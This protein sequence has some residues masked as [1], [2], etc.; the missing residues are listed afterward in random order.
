MKLTPQ[1]KLILIMLADI[2][3]KLGING[4]VDH[5]FIM[6]SIFSDNTWAIPWKLSGIFG[7]EQFDDPPEVEEVS[8]ILD[9]WSLIEASYSALSVEEKTRIEKEASHFSGE[10]KFTGFDGN[11]ESNHFSIAKHFIKELGRWTEFD[12]RDLNS[13]ARSL[14]VYQRMLK[15][16]N[17]VRETNLNDLLSAGEII[18]ILKAQKHPNG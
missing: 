16:L 13:H 15:V 3:K 17:R 6:K 18:K 7:D 5:E 9:M 4:E 14:P 2:H 8:D 12:G 11:N 10:V 1:E